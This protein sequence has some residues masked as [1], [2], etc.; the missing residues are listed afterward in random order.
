MNKTARRWIGLI[1]FVTLI[2]CSASSL[3]KVDKVDDTVENWVNLGTKAYD[4]GDY[5]R[6]RYSL[7][8]IVIVSI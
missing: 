2:F 4:Q 7:L 3:A 1:L 8:L 5:E 6:T